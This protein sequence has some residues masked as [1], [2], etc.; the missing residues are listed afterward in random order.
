MKLLMILMFLVGPLFAQVRHVVFDLDSTLIQGIP[1][2]KQ[3]LVKQAQLFQ[4]NDGR[5]YTYVVRTHA[6]E[7]IERLI[8]NDNF[9][10][11]IASDLPK[12][13]T[14]LILNK[15]QI[16]S[17]PLKTVIEDGLGSIIYSN[18]V[19][20]KKITSDLNNSIYITSKAANGAIPAENTLYLGQYQYYFDTYA[21]A[22]SEIQSL[23]KAGYFSNHQQYLPTSQD[24]FDKEKDKLAVTYLSLLLSVKKRD[25]TDNVR[26]EYSD[27]NTFANARLVAQNS[28]QPTIFKV[29]NGRCISQDIT[30]GNT[31]RATR[32][33]CAQALNF[34]LNWTSNSCAYSQADGTV[35]LELQLDE[36]VQKL[37]TKSY[38]KGSKQNSCFAFAQG[39]PRLEIDSSNCS[40][41]HAIF[42]KK[43]NGYS[44]IAYFSGMEDLTEDQIIKER[45][46]YKPKFSIAHHDPDVRVISSTVFPRNGKYLW[47]A[48]NTDQYT[49]F[50][51]IKA[52]FGNSAANVESKV[53]SKL[54]MKLMG[55]SS[56]FPLLGMGSYIDSEL[57]KASKE[58]PLTEVEASS[59]AKKIMDGHFFSLPFSTLESQSL[60]RWSPAYL[61]WNPWLVFSSISPAICYLYNKE[62]L[63]SFKEEDKRSLDL[64]YYNYVLNGAWR[65][66]YGSAAHSD[67]GEFITPGHIDAKDIKGFFKTNPLNSS[68]ELGLLKFSYKK[69]TY[70]A[71]LVNPSGANCFVMN[72]FYD[73][74]RECNY[75]KSALYVQDTEDGVKISDR[76][77]P[78]DFVIALCDEGEKCSIEKELADRLELE[79]NPAPS[80]MWGKSLGNI[81]INGK[82]PKVFYSA[83]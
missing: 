34:P 75:T 65:G 68:V 4:V 40:N 72:D 35:Y 47:R 46:E 70:I 21:I 8:G 25:F 66:G 36:C 59:R 78:A 38:W 82:V 73:S 26:S 32:L 67:T 22:Q 12:T 6:K 15:I 16:H 13:R 43:K 23:K 9:I 55:K 63:V 50:D 33:E 81:T 18:S 14:D 52:M 19:S 2:S 49:K 64:T 57:S 24:S 71:G 5:A 7:V 53:F 45:L 61:D 80:L 76:T 51:A 60:N 39:Q 3:S 58:I 11:H 77:F 20:L 79:T 83:D 56:P 62:V 69:K 74:I 54:K 17:T 27:A 28:Y 10:V 44:F 31:S 42:D 1:G 37:A 30:T 48:M 29:K 41:T